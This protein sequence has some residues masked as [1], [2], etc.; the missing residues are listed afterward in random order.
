VTTEPGSQVPFNAAQIIKKYRPHLANF[1]LEE[2]D[3]ENDL[4]AVLRNQ[5]IR[6]PNGVPGCGLFQVDIDPP[7][8]Y[9]TT[10][11]VTLP[12][13]LELNTNYTLKQVWSLNVPSQSQFEFDGL[14]PSS[15]LTG[16]YAGIKN[17][18]VALGSLTMQW[19]TDGT[20]FAVESASECA[21]TLCVNEYYTR[22]NGTAVN[23]DI[24]STHYGT[25]DA[26]TGFGWATWSA[27]VN[28]TTYLVND[29]TYVPPGDGPSTGEQLTSIINLILS[30]TLGV[31]SY[32]GHVICDV[33]VTKSNTTNGTADTVVVTDC[34]P[35]TDFDG[36]GYTS[37]PIEIIDTTPRGLEAVLENIVA[38][39]TDLFQ[40]YG[41]VDVTGSAIST[42]NFVH[43]RWVW[44]SLPL[45][46]VAVT[47]LALLATVVQT[48]RKRQPVWRSSVLPLV[49]RGPQTLG[50]GGNG[51]VSRGAGG[52]D[53]VSDRVVD[54]RR[55]AGSMY[56]ALATD[57]ASGLRLRASSGSGGKER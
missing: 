24:L 56:V 28:D 57:A 43:I 10:G 38:A 20:E 1:T 54:M 4:V 18:L 45:V 47:V 25:V 5:T 13:T 26:H 11:K 55:G 37:V 44:L 6:L 30:A 53:D 49:L 42:V 23:S 12:N 19:N 3:T 16:T 35:V 46:V 9:N 36:D 27:V 51:E 50:G 48:W 41:N 33:D 7:S 52:W 32:M 31:K 29:G 34:Q 17:P 14:A 21:M 8:S 22:V 2:A 15:W 40:R 39:A